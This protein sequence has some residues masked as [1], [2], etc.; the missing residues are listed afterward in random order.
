MPQQAVFFGLGNIIPEFAMELDSMSKEFA[1]GTLVQ[2]LVIPVHQADG[3]LAYDGEPGCRLRGKYR[4]TLRVI[5][6]LQFSGKFTKIPGF[7]GIEG[8]NRVQK[9]RSVFYIMKIIGHKWIVNPAG[10]TKTG[11]VRILALLFS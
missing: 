2:K 4:L 10:Q 7:Q 9:F 5:G 6:C 1:L 11:P 3:A 8:V